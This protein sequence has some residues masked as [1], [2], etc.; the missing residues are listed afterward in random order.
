MLGLRVGVR[1]GRGCRINWVGPSGSV[2]VRRG[3]VPNCPVQEI[4]GDRLGKHHVSRQLQIF[5]P[6]FVMYQCSYFPVS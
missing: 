1:F 6:Q 4:G 3:N 2:S 5:Q